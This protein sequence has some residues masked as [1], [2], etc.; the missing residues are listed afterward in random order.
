MRKLLLL[1]VALAMAVSPVLAYPEI[2]LSAE[3]D[4]G[5]YKYGEV[6][7]VTGS[8]MQGGVGVE[9]ATVIFE[10]ID[11]DGNTR[12][13]WA[14]LT[15]DDGGFTFTVRLPSEWPEG[16]YTLSVWAQYLDEVSSKVNLTFTLAATLGRI[17]RH[18]L[19]N[20]NA[21][22]ILP[23]THGKPALGRPEVG[24]AAYSDWTAA[25]YVGGLALYEPVSYTHLTLPTTE[26]V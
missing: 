17:Y 3:L 22:M 1:S 24:N 20:E 10:F 4:K 18:V 16:E 19:E 7:T 26:R 15:G 12:F 14:V 8:V 13:I 11:P 2:T 25:G 9:N 5:L 6:L 21:F 23:N